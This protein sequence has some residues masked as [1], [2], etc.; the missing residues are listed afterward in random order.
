MRSPLEQ[1]SCVYAQVCR[2]WSSCI[3]FK[4]KTRKITN[5]EKG[6]S[7]QPEK[8]EDLLNQRVSSF[9]TAPG[10]QYM[11]R[12]APAVTANLMNSPNFLNSSTT[13]WARENL[14]KGGV[15]N[16]LWQQPV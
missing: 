16:R 4:T 7:A 14:S 11:I 13:V 3:N 1:S 9:H 10:R 12:Q 8:G 6:A 15:A 2:T 5:K